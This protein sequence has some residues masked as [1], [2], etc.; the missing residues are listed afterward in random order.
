MR[1]FDDL[2]AAWGITAE[3][4][5]LMPRRLNSFMLQREEKIKA[6]EGVLT[7]ILAGHDVS[8]VD[9]AAMNK[10]KRILKR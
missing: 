3:G 2:G 8:S 6:L 4:A 9:Y 1:T 5:M 7:D 10:A